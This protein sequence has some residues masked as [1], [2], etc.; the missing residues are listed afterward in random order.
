MNSEY[1]KRLEPEFGEFLKRLGG[2][3]RK[4]RKAQSYSDAEG[5]GNEIDVS[6]STIRDYETGRTRMTLQRFYTIMRGLGKTPEEVFTA[7]VLQGGP[8][9]NLPPN[10]LPSAKE[11]QLRTQVNSKLGAEVA[12]ALSSEE[13]YRL[14]EM[15]RL[16]SRREV[17]KSEMRDHF[18]LTTYTRAFNRLLDL[19]RD[20]GLIRLKYP[21]SLHHKNQRYL[22]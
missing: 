12:N 16:A 13:V 10:T 18:G 6:G 7:L 22:A 14:H 2:F 17:R 11:Q 8:A 15:V 1:E 19:A 20:A 5:F 9:E 3:I 4:E 21:E